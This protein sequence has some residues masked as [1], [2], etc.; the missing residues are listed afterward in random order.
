MA[1]RNV[2]TSSRLHFGVRHGDDLAAVVLI[3]SI[4]DYAF[5]RERRR[6]AKWR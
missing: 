4:D 5:V 2:A 3:A 6:D 1:L